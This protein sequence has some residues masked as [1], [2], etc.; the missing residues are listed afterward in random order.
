[1]HIRKHEKSLIAIAFVRACFEF[2]LAADLNLKVVY[3][4]A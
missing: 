3:I 1:M 2:N 4:N